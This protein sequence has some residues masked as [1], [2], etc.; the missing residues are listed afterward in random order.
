MLRILTRRRVQIMIQVGHNAFVLDQRGFDLSFL[1]KDNTATA[2]KAPEITAPQTA[3]IEA[4]LSDTKAPEV[5]TQEPQ[6]P[7]PE[8][9]PVT[10]TFMS[11]FTDVVE[12]PQL[13]VDEVERQFMETMTYQLKAFTAKKIDA[14]TGKEFPVT[15]DKFIPTSINPY[16]QIADMWQKMAGYPHVVDYLE[17]HQEG[18]WIYMAATD[19]MG[20]G[21][22]PMAV[23][24][25]E[26]QAE[27]TTW[28]AFEPIAKASLQKLLNAAMIFTKSYVTHSIATE[29]F[30]IHP[31][32]RK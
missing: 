20:L 21:Y 28:E 14:R 3:P 24:L 17:V 32:T 6:E 5:I 16:Q 1:F 10:S 30:W 27:K 13:D 22:K 18:E 31:Q 25:L 8:A 15:I 19:Y 29:L 9:T 7:L 12:L 23:Y 11:Q 4:T 26:Q 2:V